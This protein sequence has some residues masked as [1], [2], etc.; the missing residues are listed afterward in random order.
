MLLEIA[1][2]DALGAG[3]EYNDAAL[4]KNR[5]N[6]FSGFIQHAK[7]HGIKPGMYTDDTQMSIAIAE[8]IIS[9]EPWQPR[10][11]AAHFLSAFLRDPRDGYARGF[12][13]FLETSE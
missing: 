3:Y 12:Q 11:I 8:A 13:S 7:H 2:G 6:L 9:G 4:E 1:I 5:S 10:H